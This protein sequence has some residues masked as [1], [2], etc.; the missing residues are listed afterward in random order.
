MNDTTAL[1][2]Q[3]LVGPTERAEL[4]GAEMRYGSD[5]AGPVAVLAEPFL[6]GPVR[7]AGRVLV[8]GVHDAGMVER[9]LR[10]R[11][12]FLQL[13]RVTDAAGAEAD[14]RLGDV[15]ILC[16]SIAHVPDTYDLVVALGGLDLVGSPDD[17]EH[18]WAAAVQ[19]LSARV[20]PGG[21]LVV[22]ASNAFGLRRLNSLTRTDRTDDHATDHDSLTRELGDAGLTVTASLAAFP[23][24]T[25]ARL[26]VHR[27]LLDDPRR[28]DLSAL[29][30]AAAVGEHR[31]DA[32]VSDPRI[33]ARDAVRRGMGH[34]LAGGWVVAA[35]RAGAANPDV[36]VI[37]V[38]GR[39]FANLDAADGCGGTVR[40]WAPDAAVPA[41]ELLAE[42]L[43]DACGRHDLD[44]VRGLLTRYASWLGVSPDSGE[45][46]ADRCGATPSAILDDHS[47]FHIL[48][49]GT[50]TATVPAEVALAAGLLEFADDAQ[51]TGLAHPWPATL[52][53]ERLAI[54]LAAMAGVAIT[55]A[56]LAA[57]RDLTGAQETVDADDESAPIG[58]SGQLARPSGYA[59]AVRLASAI[60]RELA[61]AREQLRFLAE[62]IADR[63]LRIRQQ[64]TLR[65][66]LR[67]AR[68]PIGTVRSHSQH[69]GAGR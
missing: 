60:S 11:D 4:I 27:D 61:E 46:P 20:A 52:T 65:Q 17:P 33:L 63:D 53:P 9:L 30:V 55:D 21:V 32:V 8:A 37:A 14:P 43:S 58:P 24:L 6:D 13:R 12:G 5:P 38:S 26:L 67:F 57:A 69:G 15:R 49:P 45:C 42:R 39:P 31:P 48:A 18:G 35:H 19:A 59:E 64:S 36:P 16:G 47:T 3:R 28:R 56:D 1:P 25:Q 44:A 41:G 68:R 2:A 29:L 23:D 22:A 7:S 66:L 62:T 54:R 34:A 40:I 51:A 50:G 10:D